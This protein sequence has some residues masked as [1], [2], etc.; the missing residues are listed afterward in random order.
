MAG[1]QGLHGTRDDGQQK[2]HLSAPSLRDLTLTR[3]GT[4]V[5]EGPRT[6][7]FLHPTGASEMKTLVLYTRQNCGL[8][9]RA[10]N[11]VQTVTATHPATVRIVDIDRDLPPHDPRRSR[12]ALELPVLEVD[13]TEAFKHSIDTEGLRKL[14]SEG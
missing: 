1:E 14:L 13:G 5:T 3:G 4:K 7:S 6:D 10:K 11:V 9:D 8:C 2:R 12:F